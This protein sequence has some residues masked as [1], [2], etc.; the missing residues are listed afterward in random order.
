[1]NTQETSADFYDGKSAKRHAALLSV[2]S[3]TVK[4]AVDGEVRFEAPLSAA[5][6]CPR[7]R[8][9]PRRI[10]FA[11]GAALL[12][13]DHAFVDAAFHVSEHDTLAHRLESHIGFVLVSL[14]G[15]AVAMVLGYLYGIPFAAREIALRMPDG[16]ERNIAEQGLNSL[17]QMVFERST[18]SIEKQKSIAN[19]FDT[20]R[21]EAGLPKE[22]R[23][24]F[25]EGDWI[26][27]NALA[28]PG[29]VV[30][31]TD[32]LIQAM[33]G[34]DEVAAV[35]AHELGHVQHRHSLRHLL[36][37][38]ITAL[39]AMAVFG[40]VTAITGLAAT[41]PTVLVE[42]GYSRDFERE[43]DAFAFALLR[44]I[45]RSPKA[46]A[47]AMES[48][49]AAHESPSKKRRFPWQK[50]TPKEPESSSPTQAEKSAEATTKRE[51]RKA[52][53]KKSGGWSS[54]LSTHPDTAERIEAALR[55]AE[56]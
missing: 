45:G 2:E 40:D 7:L 11:D 48:L 6:V 9:T 27:A 4:I 17:D 41:A 54:Y 12:V 20:L 3:G 15:I 42:T 30:V 55:A 29:G 24:E 44:K 51:S 34:D 33:P 26:G 5:R 46:F 49:E 23:L 36:Q 1:M 28:L 8:G 50:K 39:G 25:R 53:K 47:R 14:L 38:S 21:I 10:E 43:S 18:L 37:S 52:D 13:A 22:V 35:L 32:E 16:L 31:I 19:L 56:K